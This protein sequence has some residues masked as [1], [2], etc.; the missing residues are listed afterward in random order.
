MIRSA[1]LPF[2]A[3]AILKIPL[4]RNLPDD[5]LIWMGNNQGEFTVKS[6]YHITHYMVETKEEVENSIGD[7]FKPLWK[8]L[9]CLKLPA[10]VKIFTWRAC[11]NGLPTME[12][13]CSRGISTST[14]CPICGKELETVHHALLL[15]D[16]ANLVWNCW[17]D[18][19][20]MILRNKWT[21]HDSTMYN[22]AH[23]PS[24]DLELF[25]TA[26]WAIWLNRNK[27]IHDDKCSSP[28]QVWQMAKNSIE[29]FNEAAFA[30]L[31][32]PRPSH[33]YS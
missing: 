33:V 17:S 5:K 2:E 27:V 28:S 3:D 32:T 11:I 4:S 15:C 9:W 8:N 21:F 25:L 12:K 7:P 14:E 26:T 16:F 29:E 31:Y 19:P 30:N 1:F 18:L 24:H 23:K 10:K 20:Q 6:A 22:L 13:V